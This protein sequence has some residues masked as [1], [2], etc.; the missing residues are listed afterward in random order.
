M[1]GRVRLVKGAYE[2]PGRVALAR[3]LGLGAAYRSLTETLLASGH[4]CSIF[5][6]APE[7]LDHAHAFLRE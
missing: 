5:T 7:L 4:A 6:H 3:G 2:E 1:P